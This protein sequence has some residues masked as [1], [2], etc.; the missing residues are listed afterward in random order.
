[1]K[2]RQEK[3]GDKAAV[4][5]TM[6]L[7]HLEWAKTH[8]PDLAKALEPHLEGECAVFVNAPVLAT[9]WV[10]LRC[11]VAI[12]RAIARVSGAPADQT[13]RDLG[14]H[15]ATLNLSGVYRSYVAGEPHAFFEKV[16][17]LHGRFQNFGRARYERLGER[18]GRTTLEGYDE[19]SPV[20]CAGSLGYCEEALRLMFVP[21]PIQVVEA[22][23]QC[24]GDPA[25]V[26]Q[27]SW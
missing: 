7:A 16:S 1:M 9:A 23:C 6:L 13:Y 4:K 10:P 21:G 24:A 19:Y 5:A 26:F 3:L 11:L 22:S 25:C 8:L 20:F 17:Q 18:S 12:D 27:L 2:A 14:R 15:S